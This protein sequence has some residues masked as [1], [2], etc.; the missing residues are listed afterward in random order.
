MRTTTKKLLYVLGLALAFALG[1]C[2]MP[3]P[4]ETSISATTQPTPPNP[5]PDYM[6]GRESMVTVY[7]DSARCSGVVTIDRRHVLTA[8]HC[9]EGGRDIVGIDN[10]DVHG[11]IVANDG[12]DHVIVLLDRELPKRYR[13]AK[14]KL[15]MPPPGT[16]L[17]FWGSPGDLRTILRKGYVA[18]LW[19]ADD[20]THF[21]VI[22]MHTWHGD[23]GG[24]FFDKDGNVVA[25]LYGGYS[26]SLGREYWDITIVQPFAFQP[27]QLK[28][29]T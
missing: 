28:G 4:A 14:I 17:Y 18:G 26:E 9:F 13:P 1:T 7:M 22:E 29:A 21:V 8:T 5:T 12:N 2:T 11:R 6:P 23:S 3:S 24:A 25:I 16:D 27:H 19:D 20:G 10:I 15:T